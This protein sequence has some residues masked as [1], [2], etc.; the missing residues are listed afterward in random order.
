MRRFH[1]FLHVLYAG[2]L[3]FSLCAFAC[4][5][6]AGGAMLWISFFSLAFL[7][8]AALNLLLLVAGS[9]FKPRR[10]LLLPLAGFLLQADNLF[11]IWQFPGE[12]RSPSGGQPLTVVTYNASHFYWNKRYTLTEAADYIK[13]LAPDIVCLQEAPNNNFY[14]TDSIHRAFSYLPFRVASSRTDHLPMMIY[15]RYPLRPVKI[16]NY[17]HSLNSTLVADVQVGNSTIRVISNHLQTTGVNQYLGRVIAPGKPWRLRLSGGKILLRVLFDNFRKRALQANLV[18]SEIRRSPYPVIVCGDFN[19]T[20]ASYAYHRIGEGL[21]DGFR[22]AGSGY[23]YTFRQLHKL[24]R[25]DYIFYSPR[26]KG[27]SCDA[28]DLP[29]SDHAPVVWRGELMP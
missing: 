23:Q 18:R 4:R 10:W 12:A 29:Y 26:F 19:D 24:W 22:D 28:P 16:I 7:P 17:R 2:G 15:S 5:F 11:A 14:L 25:I 9:F 21:T 8:V 27:I 3:F 1:T 20:P 6:A 13:Q